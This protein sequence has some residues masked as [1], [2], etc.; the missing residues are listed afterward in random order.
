MRGPVG[1]RSGLTGLSSGSVT[2]VMIG[3]DAPASAAA[4]PNFIAGAP[5]SAAP[6]SGAAPANES[7]KFGMRTAPSWPGVPEAS[8]YAPFASLDQPLPDAYAGVALMPETIE[9]PALPLYMSFWNV[10]SPPTW[11]TIPLGFQRW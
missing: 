8:A 5:A 9:V 10:L 3:A 2:T 6:T 4:R 1:R 11:Y 7:L